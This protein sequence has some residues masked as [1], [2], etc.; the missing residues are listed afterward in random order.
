MIRAIYHPGKSGSLPEM[1]LKLPEDECKAPRDGLRHGKT[2]DMLF[3]ATLLKG[4][5]DTR[6]FLELR[7][8]AIIPE[9]VAHDGGGCNEPVQF[10]S[11]IK[12]A[13]VGR[14]FRDG[15]FV[16]RR[17]L[18]SGNDSEYEMRF[19]GKQLKSARRW[20]PNEPWTMGKTLKWPFE[21]GHD[22]LLSDLH[23]TALLAWQEVR[24]LRKGEVYC[25]LDG[26]VVPVDSE[27]ISPPW[28]WEN[29]CGRHWRA[30]LCPHCL[31]Q[32]QVK[33]VAMN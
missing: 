33:V 28:T 7:G 3:L 25:P 14:W 1:F 5:G 31:G 12:R 8:G 10:K 15:F 32:F 30:L 6:Y 19:T 17:V 29:L 24:P 4:A 21:K 18:A 26:P 11:R 27:L 13:T 16:T 22:P 9:L 20:K 23:K 2:E